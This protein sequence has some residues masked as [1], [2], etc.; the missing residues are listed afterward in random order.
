M[1]R[2]SYGRGKARN[3]RRTRRV[4]RTGGAPNL[5]VE[6]IDL[7]LAEPARGPRAKN[8]GFERRFWNGERKGVV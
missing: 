8:W 5:M 2:R 6:C 3:E 7:Y 1:D 4:E